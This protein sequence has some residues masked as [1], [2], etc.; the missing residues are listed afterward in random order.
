MKV[1]SAEQGSKK[2]PGQATSAKP[3]KWASWDFAIADQ[4]PEFLFLNDPGYWA[5]TSTMA[6]V[7][8]PL[9]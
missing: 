1:R 9:S 7:D 4:E 6:P 5:E 3:A 2:P 8:N